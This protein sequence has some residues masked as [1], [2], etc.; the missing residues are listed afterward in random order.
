MGYKFRE[1]EIP[2]YMMEG[3]DR[4][5][6]K[7]LEPGSFLREILCDNFV[8]AAG[9]A[10]DNNLRNLPAY[11]AYLYNVMPLP[12]WGSEEKVKAWIAKLRERK[13]K[14]DEIH[15]RN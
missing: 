2:D 11:A 15:D 1:W 12:A 8:S 7:G 9:Y 14:A 5:K 6:N 3:L 4:Y 13:V 10:D